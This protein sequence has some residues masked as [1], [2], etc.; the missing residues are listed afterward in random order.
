[1]TAKHPPSVS[2][3]Q[4]HAMIAEAAYFIAERNG[5]TS[6]PLADWLAAEAEIDSLLQQANRAPNGAAKSAKHKDVT[7]AK[8]AKTHG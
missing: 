6:D 3:E 5:F 8:P 2:P 1:M 7:A 4:R